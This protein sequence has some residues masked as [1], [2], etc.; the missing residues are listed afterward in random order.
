MYSRPRFFFRHYAAKFIKNN[1]Q[2]YGKGRE[3]LVLI[4][5]WTCN[6]DYWRDQVPDLAKR[7]RVIAI[8]LPGHGQSDKPEIAYINIWIL[9]RQWRRA[10]V[11]FVTNLPLPNLAAVLAETVFVGHDSGISHLAAALG[12]PTIVLWGASAEAVWRPKGDHVVVL[13]SEAGLSNISPAIVI[14]TLDRIV[15]DETQSQ[16]PP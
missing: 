4:H 3:A 5:G 9:Q 12:L 14:K 10:E 2:S 7:N 1:Y 6:L 8:D 13:K 16:C 15:L 11:R